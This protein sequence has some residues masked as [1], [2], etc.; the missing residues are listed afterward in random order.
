M[1]CGRECGDFRGH[2]SI[3]VTNRLADAHN[4]IECL[5][6]NSNAEPVSRCAVVKIFAVDQHRSHV[7][8]SLIID[9]M[10]R[11]WRRSFR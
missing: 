6:G 2:T 7:R 4:W 5:Q 9:R 11:Q 3:A 10:S 8:A 1:C